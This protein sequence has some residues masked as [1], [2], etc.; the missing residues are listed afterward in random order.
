MDKPQSA[1]AAAQAICLPVPEWS[2]S[3]AGRCSTGEMGVCGTCLPNIAAA[4]QC[5]VFRM[6]ACRGALGDDNRMAAGCGLLQ[7]DRLVYCV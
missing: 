3:P 6:L 2:A 5:N 7:A 4:G 1:M